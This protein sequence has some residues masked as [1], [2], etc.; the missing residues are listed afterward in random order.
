MGDFLGQPDDPGIN[1][2][3]EV[4]AI[5]SGIFIYACTKVLVMRS[6]PRVLCVFAVRI[7]CGTLS[8]I[9]RRL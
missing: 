4:L 9:F 3:N 2:L 7:I 8:A 1:C 6:F 5:T